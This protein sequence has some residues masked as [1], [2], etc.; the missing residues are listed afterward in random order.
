MYAILL[1]AH[2]IVRWL[3]LALGV[4]VVARALVGLGHSRTWAARDERVAR[5][6]VLTLDVQVLVGLL[7]H[8]GFSPITAAA[9]RDP[10][11]ALRDTVARFWL[12]EHP[13][14]M[15]AALACAHVGLIRARGAGTPALRA[16]R[17]LVWVGLAVVLLVIGIPWPFSRVAR[18]LWP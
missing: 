9:L 3:V 13:V 6:F 1:S 15:L 8:L 10:L 11:A 12:L 5:L 4:A 17:A 2:S 18:P 14:L 16:R 7:L